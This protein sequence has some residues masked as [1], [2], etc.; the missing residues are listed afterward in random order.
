MTNSA[1]ADFSSVQRAGFASR[2]R[3]AI[4]ALL[5]K[6]LFGTVSR[7]SPVVK[8]NTRFILDHSL[9]MPAKVESAWLDAVSFE[10]HQFEFSL[11][12]H[13]GLHNTSIFEKSPSVRYE[14]FASA[15][16]LDA[17]IDFLRGC[18]MFPG[19]TLSVPSLLVH[20]FIAAW[21]RGDPESYASVVEAMGLNARD[22]QSMRM[23]DVQAR[24]DESVLANARCWFAMGTIDRF[25]FIE[26][27]VAVDQAPKID[28]IRFDG[29]LSDSPKGLP[30]LYALDE[31]CHVIGGKVYRFDANAG[32]HDLV[33][34]G[35]DG[36][37]RPVHGAQNAFLASRF[38]CRKDFDVSDEPRI[39]FFGTDPEDTNY[40]PKGFS[41]GMRY[42]RD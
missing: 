41:E 30:N 40:V 16:T 28:G 38:D 32:S 23:I 35:S 7:M 6:D 25:R 8:N 24:D 26:V 20:S 29:A 11:P 34:L 5:A 2:A 33:A 15:V 9:V 4:N 12:R 37:P 10:N 21:K 13:Q 36:T 14:N 17:T 31:V 42:G 27:P 39:P 22:P 18:S 1:N 19:Q 3:T